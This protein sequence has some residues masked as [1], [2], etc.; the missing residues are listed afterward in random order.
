MNKRRLL[1]LLCLMALL[2]TSCDNKGDYWGAMEASETTMTLER[3]CDV[4]TL[5]QDSI[6]LLSRIMGIDT[7]EL[8]RADAVMIGKVS[9]RNQSVLLSQVC[10]CQRQNNGGSD[11]GSLYPSQCREYLLCFPGSKHAGCG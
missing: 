4:S 1:G 6:E 7:D 8:Y 2:V 10:D 9:G 3:I 11:C 5:S